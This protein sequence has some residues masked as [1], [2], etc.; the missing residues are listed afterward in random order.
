MQLRN[1]LVLV[2][3]L[4]LVVTVDLAAQRRQPDGFI[5]SRRMFTGLFGVPARARIPTPVPPAP[6][7]AARQFPANQHCV[8]CP[9]RPGPTHF[10]IDSP[11]LDDEWLANH[12]YQSNG[13]SFGDNAA[14]GDFW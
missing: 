8:G 3:G 1:T 9:E 14:V 11:R 13:S 6:A 7:P 10:V 2:T 5:A 4:L 12:R